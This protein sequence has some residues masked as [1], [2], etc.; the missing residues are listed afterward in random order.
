MSTEREIM[1]C[2]YSGNNFLDESTGSKE[3]GSNWQ[4]AAG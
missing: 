1:E 4:V 2:K 3:E